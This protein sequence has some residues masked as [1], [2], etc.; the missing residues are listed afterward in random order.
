MLTFILGC[1]Q[2]ALLFWT[3]ISVLN[4]TRD[5]ARWLVVHPHTA[6]SNAVASFTPRLPS[7]LTLS[8]LTITVSP[9]CAALTAGKCP[10]RNVGDSLVVTLAY[11]AT[12]VYFLPTTFVLGN[13]IARLPTNLPPYSLHMAVEPN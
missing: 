8:R 3:Y 2:F 11:D 13:Q 5:F 12:E 1:F 7:N 4:A 10:N 9:P 6:D